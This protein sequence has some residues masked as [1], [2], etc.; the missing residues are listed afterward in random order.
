MYS[1]FVRSRTFFAGGCHIISYFPNLIRPV[2]GLILLVFGW[3]MTQDATAGSFSSVTPLNT[4]RGGQTATL[5]TNGRLLVAG[6]QTN[7][8]FTSSTAEL[9]DPAAGTW[10]AAA[11]MNAD[12]AHHT[13]TMLPNGKVLV[14]GGFSGFNG[15][16]SSAELYDPV[17]GTWTITGPMT[18]ARFF[19]TATLL[20]DGQALVLGGTADGSNAISS[21]ELYDPATGMWTATN[22]LNFARFSHTATLLS[23]G[24]ALVAGGTSGNGALVSAVELFDPTTGIWTMTN[25]LGTPRYSHTATLL[26]TG[27]VLIAGGTTD[28]SAGI[29]SGELYNPLTGILTATNS[30]NAA[31]FNHTAT[32]LPDGTAL[33]TG[34]TDGGAS[35]T[36]AEV[37]NPNSGAWAAVNSLSSGRYSHTATMLASGE[38]LVA[39]GF[40]TNQALSSVERYNPA[41]GA[42]TNTGPMT[43]PRAAAPAI[44]LLPNG[45]ALV[46]GGVNTVNN[47]TYASAEVYDPFAGKWTAT[48]TMSSTRAGASA[49][50]LPN[51]KV[52]AMGGFGGGGGG[53]YLATAELYDPVTGK[54]ALTGPAHVP[55]AYHTAILLA[56]GSVLVAGGLTTSSGYP[57]STEL[58]NPATGK[59]TLTGSMH[60]GRDNPTVTLLSNG[61]VLVA[62][63]SGA[64]FNSVASAE[65]YDPGAGKWL[66]ASNLN[67]ARCSATATLLPNGKVLV[68]GGGRRAFGLGGALSSA[69]LYDPTTGAWTLAGPLPGP[70]NF[71]TAALLPNGKVLVAG[72]YD[73]TNG[74]NVL[75]SALLYDPPSGA[76]AATA[77]L[78][79][80]RN[81]ALMTLLPNGKALVTGGQ[82]NNYS[83]LASAE[84]YDPGLGFNAL[85]Q[86]QIASV[87]F[88]SSGG[89]TVNGLGFRGISEGSGGNSQD[90][91]ADY[92]ALEL[93]SVDS[94]QAFF[95]LAANWS[96]NSVTSQPVGGLPPGYLLATVF[97][98][99]IP[100]A[101]QIFKL[102][103]LPILAN[104]PATAIATNAATLNGQ[105]LDAGGNTPAITIYYGT[106]DGGANAAAWS[107]SVA[108]GL[109]S[110][111][112][113]QTV[114]GLVSNTTYYFTAQALNVV[115]PS[116]AIPSQ[117]FTT[118][119]LPIVTN[120]PATK[121]QATFATLNGKVIFN[122]NQTPAVTIYYGPT[123][124]GANPSAWA[125]SIALGLQSGAFAQAIDNLSTNTTYFYAVE[126][127]N[128][129]GASWAAPSQ[130]FTT[131]ASNSPAPPFVAVLTQH[132]DNGRTGMNLNETALNVSNVNTR[133]FGLLA[134]R[135]V[136]DQIYAQPLVATN[137]NILGR[138][139]HNVVVVATVN[140]TVYAYDADDPAATAPYWTNS[141][142]NP[143]DIVPPNNGDESAI[144]ACGGNYLDY[145]GNFGI[146]G[147]PVIDPMAGT[148]YVVARTKEFG[149][150]FIQ[151]LHA[152][153]ITTGLDRSNSPV[154]IAATYPGVGAGSSGGV[155][156]F[157]PLRNNQRPALALA[158]GVVYISWS[159]HC[160]NG[161]YHGWV[162][163]YNAGTLRQVAVF[164]DTPNGSEGGIW[165]SGQGPCADASGNIYLTV[166]NGS[167]DANDFGESFLKL[168]PA[169]GGVTM[170]VASFFIPL[171]WSALNSSDTDL[172]SAGL[173]MIPGT[174]LVISGGKSGTLYVVDRDDM[175]GISG[176]IQSWPTGGGEIHGGPVW[177]TG[178]NGSFMY[179]WPDSSAHLRQYPFT[180][181]FNS[182]RFSQASTVGGVG[183]PGGILSV[184]A[185]GA[186]AGGAILWAVVNTAGDANQ[187]V[188]AGTLHAY[189]AQ[190]VSSELWNS[191]VLPRDSLG[192]LAKFVPPTVA[193]GKVYMATFSGRLNV[194]GLLPNMLPPSIGAGG[195]TVSFAGSPGLSYTLQ[196][197]TTV[198]GPWTAIATVGIGL[199]GIGAYLDARPPV[200]SAFYR[201]TYP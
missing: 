174:S 36:N 182:A 106:S 16:L 186:N 136:D 14:A 180:G 169:N 153:D 24:Q 77:S 159:S 79:V 175:G 132:N 78:S 43:V 176:A 34:G 62:G 95:P 51:G 52:L 129:A 145:S 200:G 93:M 73:G 53:D 172:G 121:I 21:A 177:W 7:G 31:R 154:V 5:L 170:T 149:T 25:S 181:G 68:A 88:L 2:F 84:L 66:L 56:N 8:G 57:V 107:N 160:D 126:A 188:V 125:Q 194:Y 102:P 70:R 197:A 151:R 45:K 183:S 94:G 193:N 133:A 124:G 40:S 87:S 9:Y 47:I 27:N 13:A 48:G 201:I 198:N 91:P 118:V 190:N 82:G 38:V 119:A 63:G 37:Y 140:D 58:Y 146:V 148:I 103:T 86:P 189:N 90:S 192:S 49:T 152:L 165:M 162:I 65:L 120:L 35:L 18:A 89:V 138:G 104:L 156:S 41:A 44:T 112:F 55:R 184:S 122:G 147:T 29:S 150:N 3:L 113:A 42:W 17:A 117:S 80:A 11:P 105:V 168:S 131:A 142:I 195:V 76:W 157:D 69:E 115:G 15:A 74:A 130:S 64:D 81:L 83:C 173:L 196:R 199:G 99:G 61:K 6:G 32:L 187:A 4:A 163:G 166:G 71:H 1:G 141:F 33:V 109:Q 123:D 191:D 144:G 75:S 127:V 26:P 110:G 164:N 143:P 135:P 116:W 139:R 98:N 161:P 101:G 96:E 108:L 111:A 100:S 22:S 85:W 114:A 179:V 54:W 59:W 171:N 158:N 30:L 23:N 60:A 19:H 185:N 72:G 128:A 46:L 50:L 12:R 97:V 39:G 67:F 155:V 92:P 20:P 167:V 10:T 134:T 178:P 137:V 28:G